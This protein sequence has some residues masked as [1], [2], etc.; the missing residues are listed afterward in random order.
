MRNQ[1]LPLLVTALVLPAGFLGAGCS[2]PNDK[3]SETGE[4]H[5]GDGHDHDHPDKGP[6]GGELIELGNEA[7]HLELIHPHDH[8]DDAHEHE[9]HDH[10]HAGITVYVLDSSAKKTVSISASEISLN[11]THD[12]KP[13]Q[14][15][16][17][18]MPAKGDEAG[19]S[20]RFASDDKDLMEHFHESEHIEGT[21][22]LDIAGK[23]FRGKMTHEHDDHEGHAH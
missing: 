6:H 20:S 16:L 9:G 17:A 5:E 19:K 22:V 12:G 14:F 4:H 10:E 21:I 8:D 18:A 3:S 15:K 2:G 13:E 23:A 1:Q 11:L 7:Y